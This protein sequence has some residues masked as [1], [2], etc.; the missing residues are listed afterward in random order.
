MPC[1]AAQNAVP[2]LENLPA[3][4]LHSRVKTLEGIN[5]KPDL[6]YV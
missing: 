5:P 2:E 6:E 4:K 1:Q 3:F